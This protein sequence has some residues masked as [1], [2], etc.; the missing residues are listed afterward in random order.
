MKTFDQFHFHQNEK[1]NTYM[2]INL[3]LIK[4]GRIR[5]DGSEKLNVP[6]PLWIHL[7]RMI[8]MKFFNRINVFDMG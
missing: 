4:Y 6:R 3:S 5:G 8:V 7:K 1:K 2:S